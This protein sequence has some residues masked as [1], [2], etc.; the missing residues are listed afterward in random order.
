MLRRC[1]APEAPRREVQSPT[2]GVKDLSS[3]GI[4]CRLEVPLGLGLGGL[5]RPLDQGR[6]HLRTALLEGEL[7]AE[8]RLV[9]VGERER[10]GEELVGPARGSHQPQAE[11]GEEAG[12][13]P[14]E[15]TLLL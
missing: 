9:S 8:N 2:V 13:D 10:E 7:R 3:E 5:F 6:R 11:T 12:G 15:G 4:Y 1:Q 14:S